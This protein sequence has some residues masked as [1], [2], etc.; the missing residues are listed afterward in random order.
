MSKTERLG[1]LRAAE[2]ATTPTSDASGD[3]ADT[4]GALVAQRDDVHA[5]VRLEIQKL[6]ALFANNG[7]GAIAGTDHLAAISEARETLTPA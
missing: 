4:A 6:W 1:S 3:T 5:A 7:V 2:V